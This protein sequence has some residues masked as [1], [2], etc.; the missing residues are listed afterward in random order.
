MSDNNQNEERYNFQGFGKMQ[1]DIEKLKKLSEPI[2]EQFGEKIKE[3]LSK[4]SLIQEEIVQLVLY[5]E[6]VAE[7]EAMHQQAEHTQKLLEQHHLVVSGL[8]EEIKD[9]ELQRTIT[10]E[11]LH[12]KGMLEE[13]QRFLQIEMIKNK[14]ELAIY[15]NEH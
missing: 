7:M 4:P 14:K 1:Q 15:K 2:K 10:L 12:N 9:L 6:K 5:L 13:F 11:F 8:K 3:L